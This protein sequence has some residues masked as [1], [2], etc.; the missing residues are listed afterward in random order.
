MSRAAFK[1]VLQ[2]RKRKAAGRFTSP[3]VSYDSVHASGGSGALFLMSLP[4]ET[5]PGKG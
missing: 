2:I 3:A 1:P 4:A 5:V